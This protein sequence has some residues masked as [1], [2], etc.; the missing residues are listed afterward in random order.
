MEGMLPRDRQLV[1][2]AYKNG[3][4]SGAD[5]ARAYDAALEMYC[6]LR[7]RKLDWRSKVDVGVLIA[8]VQMQTCEAGPA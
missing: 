7:G 2:D 1:I 8:E 5:P 6:T 4:G 3:N